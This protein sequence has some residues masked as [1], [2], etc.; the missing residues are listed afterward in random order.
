MLAG[1]LKL[2]EVRDFLSES[3]ESQTRLPRKMY[4]DAKVSVSF[5]GFNPC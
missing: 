1:V 2:S 3:D 5:V 4:N